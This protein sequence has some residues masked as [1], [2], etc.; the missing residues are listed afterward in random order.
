[1]SNP[2]LKIQKCKGVLITEA[3]LHNEIKA[4]ANFT[5]LNLTSFVARPM[6][7]KV[8]TCEAFPVTNKNLVEVL[9]Q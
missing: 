3:F 8:S 9:A 1:M 4:H 7:K 5:N 2:Y 6:T